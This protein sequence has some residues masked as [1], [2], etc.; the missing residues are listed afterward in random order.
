MLYR[1]SSSSGA[2]TRPFI[3]SPRTSRVHATPLRHSSPARRSRH[4]FRRRPH[5]RITYTTSSSLSRAASSGPSSSYSSGSSVSGSTTPSYTTTALKTPEH[6]GT[7]F[8]NQNS[9]KS[10]TPG[11]DATWRFPRN[12]RMT[13]RKDSG[14]R[15]P[16]SPS[17]TSAT[18]EHNVRS[19]RRR[20][21]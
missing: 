3:A 17:T 12:T 7:S 21:I 10:A 14:T 11:T 5:Y 20:T 8:W 13:Q 9:L 18:T 1:P 6:Y 4:R 16:S 15:N 19:R 2:Y